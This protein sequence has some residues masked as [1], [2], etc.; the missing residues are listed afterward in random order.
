MGSKSYVAV[1][2]LHRAGCVGV[3]EEQDKLPLVQSVSKLKIYAESGYRGK[4]EF[5]I[6]KEIGRRVAIM[7]N[8]NQMLIHPELLYYQ[9]YR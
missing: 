2:D 3:H 4:C 5:V 7:R 9:L 6:W 8:A 1:I